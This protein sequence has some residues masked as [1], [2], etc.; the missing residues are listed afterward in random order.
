MCHQ[1][2]LVPPHLSLRVVLDV[3]RESRLEGLVLLVVHLDLGPGAKLIVCCHL[4]LHGL[5]PPRPIRTSARHLLICRR[6]VQVAARR[7]RRLGTACQVRLWVLL[8]PWYFGSWLALRALR[9]QCDAVTGRKCLTY[10]G[11]RVIVAVIVL[12]Q[13]LFSEGT[14]TAI[15][16]ACERLFG[17]VLVPTPAF[18]VELVHFP[19]RAVDAVGVSPAVSRGPT[20]GPTADVSILPEFSS[21]STSRR[22]KTSFV[23]SSRM[24]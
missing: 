9:P 19:F 23:S 4:L 12:F 11:C 20:L 16:V 17:G 24:R 6:L 10:P 15:F 22:S 8:P 13:A 18:G 5:L 21:I 2:G 14:R 3:E 1:A 7:N